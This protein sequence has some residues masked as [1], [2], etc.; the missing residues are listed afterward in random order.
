MSNI[1]QNQINKLI[2]KDTISNT[3][4]TIFRGE[5]VDFLPPCLRYFTFSVSVCI[6]KVIF[7]LFKNHQTFLM[8]KDNKL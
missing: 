1:Q 4:E 7:K 8:F 3:L 2:L 5:P 6:I